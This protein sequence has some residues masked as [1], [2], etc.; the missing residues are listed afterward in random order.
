MCTAPWLDCEPWKRCHP[1]AGPAWLGLPDGAPKRPH[2]PRFTEDA[3]SL[4]V[5]G[6]LCDRCHPPLPEPV[7]GMVRS[8]ES[9]APEFPAPLRADCRKS[10]RDIC[11]HR[12]LL[13]RER[14]P[15]DLRRLAA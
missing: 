10:D 12:A 14:K 2:P 3:G 1:R 13:L 8:N 7:F 11:S 15:F 5:A 6:L 4:R 9:S